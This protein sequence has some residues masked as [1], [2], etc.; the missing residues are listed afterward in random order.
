MIDIGKA[1]QT[2]PRFSTQKS[3][4]NVGKGKINTNVVKMYN[5]FRKALIIIIKNL[6]FWPFLLISVRRF[7]IYRCH[8]NGVD[9]I[10]VRYFKKIN[11]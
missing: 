7:T 4:K 10:K 6:T 3:S 11:G 8:E 1:I 9:S 2:L 5:F